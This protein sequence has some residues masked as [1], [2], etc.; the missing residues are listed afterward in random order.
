MNQRT[1]T[2]AL[3]L[4][5]PAARTWTSISN[6]LMDLG[7]ANEA[8]MLAARSDLLGEVDVEEWCEQA[9]ARAALWEGMGY[10]WLSLTE[11]G[12]PQTLK[13]LDQVPPLLFYRGVLRDDEASVSVVGSREASAEAEAEAAAVAAELARRGVPV[14]SG[15]ARGIDS[16]AHRAT[17]DAGGRPIA[18]IATGIDKCYPAENRDLTAQVASSG[19]VFSQFLP[20]TSPAK[21]Q[22]L[23]RNK[24]MAAYSSVTLVVQGS[25]Q[26]G[27]RAQ[28]RMAIDHGRPVVLSHRVAS[29]TSWGNR[30]IG[31]PSVRVARGAEEMTEFAYRAL[32]ES[33]VGAE[34]LR[35]LLRVGQ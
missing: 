10:E 27:A 17:I 35:R 14:V 16:A 25:E 11:P 33:R 12:F 34:Q 8:L 20:G 4:G 9:T 18:F 1:A 24:L 31:H 26:S 15:L 7:D 21:H 23:M 29:S 30:L 5:R 3:L 2:L 13:S 6:W 22:F 19:C 28:C 32:P